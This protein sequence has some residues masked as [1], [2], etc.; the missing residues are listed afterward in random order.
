MSDGSLIVRGIGRLL[1]M[2]GDPPPGPAA[3]VIRDG[4]VE[5][6]GADSDLPSGAELPTYDAGGACVVPG[7]VDAHT[8]LV[9]AGSRREEFLARL[10]G[11]AYDGGGIQTTVTATR[12][13]SDDELL[14]L[15]TSRVRQMLANGTTTVEV[16]S[17]YGLSDESELRL[18]D[19]VAALG[20]RTPIQIDATYL[21]A[22][23]VPAGR[24]RTDYVDEVIATLPAAA[25][26]GARWCDVFCDSGA[27]DVA[28]TERI[29]VAAR[30]AG[31]GLRMHAEQLARTGASTLAAALGC[32]SA[33]H[34]EKVTDTDARA[35][36]DAQVI[37]VL[38][39]TAAMS[40]R[41]NSHDHV[42]VLRRA[43]V[44]FALAT[45]CNPGTSW[46]ESMPYV[47]QLGC[48]DFGLSV[49]EA[50]TAATLG[51]AMALQKPDV[52]NLS[53]GARGDL[54][55]LAAEHEADVVAHLGGRAVDVTVVGGEV[56]LAES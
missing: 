23:V 4:R 20:A 16:K 47:I 40:L 50:F 39:P 8:H 32:A 54:A 6:S 38:L 34:L 30:D 44:R 51:G 22:H 17:G 19:I 24:D 29:L 53:I 21:G 11:T 13:A 46:C 25:E 3:I 43:G 7:F 48:L 18:L 26:H 31:L 45:D 28:E 49:A 56:W 41:D 52:G 55:I 15:A 36:A 42:D 33:D 9:W 35:L 5:W 2:A 37:G 1:T 14:A 10:A 12:A 27:F